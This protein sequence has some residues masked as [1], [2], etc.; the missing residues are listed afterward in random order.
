VIVNNS[1][2]KVLDVPQASEKPG[3]RVVIWDKNYRWNQRWF[4]QKSSNNKYLI[5]NLVSGQCLDIAGESK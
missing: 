4:F 2:G 5:K 1:S 3:T